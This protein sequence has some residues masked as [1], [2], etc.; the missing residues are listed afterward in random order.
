M[1]L[2][3][4]MYLFLYLLWTPWPFWRL[5]I[6]DDDL[7]RIGDEVNHNPVYGLRSSW[8]EW[9]FFEGMSTDLINY[10]SCF[11][12]HTNLCMASIIL[13]RLLL[14]PDSG[15]VGVL[16]VRVDHLLRSVAT[17][18]KGEGEFFVIVRSHCSKL[19]RYCSSFVLRFI[20]MP[21]G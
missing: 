5:C 19:L 13:R 4:Y 21:I 14:W 10:F 3:L 1:N 12:S 16:L 9:L 20:T 15:S 18:L 17:R 2:E 11:V 6:P 8:D 7:K